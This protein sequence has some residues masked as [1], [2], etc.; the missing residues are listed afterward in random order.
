[1]RLGA[2]G[3]RYL[4]V[5]TIALLSAGEGTPVEPGSGLRSGASVG[6]D[7]LRR[8]HI[9]DDRANC[10]SELRAHSRPFAFSDVAPSYGCANAAPELVPDALAVNNAH[11]RRR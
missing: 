2:W 3:L 10:P 7:D 4:L 11:Y 6:T 8:Y 1:M 9:T 5:S